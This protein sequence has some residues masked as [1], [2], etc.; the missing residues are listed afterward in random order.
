MKKNSFEFTRR[1]LSNKGVIR[2]RSRVNNFDFSNHRIEVV[3]YM[4]GQ[5][6]DSDRFFTSFLINQR[7]QAN[8]Y[9]CDISTNGQWIS[10]VEIISHDN[11]DLS[12]IFSE[13]L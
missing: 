12:D 7:N 13:L 6:N 4:D 8:P 3:V 10:K 9:S 1:Q 5:E 2:I 11:S